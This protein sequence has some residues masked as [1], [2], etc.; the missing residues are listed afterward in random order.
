MAASNYEVHVM[1]CDNDDVLFK[2][3]LVKVLQ[4]L[5]L[6]I[7]VKSCS[8]DGEEDD[9]KEEASDAEILRFIYEM[10]VEEALDRLNMSIVPES[11]PDKGITLKLRKSKI[12][13]ANDEELLKHIIVNLQLRTLYPTHVQIVIACPDITFEAIQALPDSKFLH[14]FYFLV[15]NE[16]SPK[17]LT[18]DWF[19]RLRWQA[20][21]GRQTNTKSR[22][23]GQTKTS[24]W[25]SFLTST[26]VTSASPAGIE[27]FSKLLLFQNSLCQRD[28]LTSL[29]PARR[30]WNT[31][32]RFQGR[33]SNLFEDLAM[34]LYWYGRKDC[35][36]IAKE[37]P[38]QRRS[39]WNVLSSW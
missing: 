18:F 23:D 1:D 38:I 24:K 6:P 22:L 17:L 4:T 7:K 27:N 21:G 33:D 9:Y 25:K 14:K 39:C 13:V 37:L 29:W 15:E 20:A 32:F 30:G 3:L 8:S 2:T 16:S 28:L 5:Q 10:E 11:K 34:D 19:T 12:I 26:A 35:W 31:R 36:A